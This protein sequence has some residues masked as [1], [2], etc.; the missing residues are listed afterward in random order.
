MRFNPIDAL[1]STEHACV[2]T[3]GGLLTEQFDRL[4][5][6][7]ETTLRPFV[8]NGGTVEFDMPS[9]IIRALKA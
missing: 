4:L 3:L 9:L 2:W 7:P 8:I 5:K 1:L 6:E